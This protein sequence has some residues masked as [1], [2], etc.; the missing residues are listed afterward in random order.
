[1]A[2]DELIE[3]TVGEVMVGLVRDGRREK[4]TVERMKMWLLEKTWG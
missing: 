3:K 2:G 1:L 4:L